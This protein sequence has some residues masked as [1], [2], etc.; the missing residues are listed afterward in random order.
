MLKPG[1]ILAFWCYQNCIVDDDIDPIVLGIF[2]EVEDYWP[3]EREIVED[4]YPTI[5]MP[6]AEVVIGQFCIA[7]DWS[8]DQLLNYMRTWSAT[9]RFIAAQGRDPV[10]MHGGRLR[11][12]WGAGTRQVRW[13]IILRAGR[14]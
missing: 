12:A 3:P 8:A 2:N 13:P 5:S 1:G 10:E 14:K 11:E 4:E 9:Q 6:F 7:A